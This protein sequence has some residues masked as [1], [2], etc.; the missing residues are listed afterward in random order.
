MFHY[1]VPFNFAD[2]LTKYSLMFGYQIT[3]NFA[4]NVAK[5]SL[6]FHYQVAFNFADDVA[7]YSLSSVLRWHSTLLMMWLSIPLVQF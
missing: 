7:K 5:Y 4:D 2:G 6:R 3:F 1:R